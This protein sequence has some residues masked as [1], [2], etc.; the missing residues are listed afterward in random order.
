MKIEQK[1][2]KE[3]YFG[4]YSI[5]FMTNKDG[6]LIQSIYSDLKTRAFGFVEK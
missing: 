3:S 5:R 4:P 1:S 6:N 2:S